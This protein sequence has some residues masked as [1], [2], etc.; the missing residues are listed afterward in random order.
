[1][2]E[3]FNSTLQ[4][5]LKAV[6]NEERDDWDDHINWALMAYRSS[7]QESTGCT[8]YLLMFG[9]EMTL[10]IDIMMGVP[11]S[12]AEHYR[13]QT[14]Y[15]EW[16]RSALQRAHEMAR[17]KL[18]V[19]ARRQKNYYDARSKPHKYQVGEFVWRWY[20]PKANRKL[21]RGWVGPY[22][23]MATPTQVNCVIQ[24][25]PDLRPVRVH[26]DAVKPHWGPIPRAWADFESAES[27]GQ[28]EESDA[29]STREE[30]GTPEDVR[31]E[32]READGDPGSGVR[33]SRAGETHLD[34]AEEVVED[35]EVS[36]DNESEVGQSSGPEEKTQEK[37]SGRPKRSCKPPNRLDL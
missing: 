22:R 5:M 7:V 30:M 3:R 24:L 36:S 19:A 35:A 13:C 14:E 28:S 6:V 32:P 25:T 17:R 31:F 21:S 12:Q 1:M 8:P 11:R 9:R 20:P 23:I 10:P 16:L 34:R 4:T 29:G 26:C 15:V 33:G 37:E 18:K 2:I 27:E